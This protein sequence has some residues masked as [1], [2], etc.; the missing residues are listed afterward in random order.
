MAS[1]VA[2]GERGAKDE[3]WGVVTS[4][5]PL[6]GSPA[7]HSPN[8][9][10]L[11]ALFNSADPDNPNEANNRQAQE[12]ELEKWARGLAFAALANLSRSMPCRQLAFKLA[13]EAGVPLPYV[14]PNATTTS[15][16]HPGADSALLKDSVADLRHAPPPPAWAYLG[17]ELVEALNLRNNGSSDGTGGAG[18]AAGGRK[19]LPLRPATTG[20]IARRRRGGNT[21]TSTSQDWGRGT[22]VHA[23]KAHRAAMKQELEGSREGDLGL[24]IG[25]K[26]TTMTGEGIGADEGAGKTAPDSVTTEG[27]HLAAVISWFFGADKGQRPHGAPARVFVP[28]PHAAPGYSNHHQDN[29]LAAAGAAADP[30]SSAFHAEA[31]P[32]S[33]AFHAEAFPAGD[34]AAGDENENRNNTERPL[35]PAEPTHL[36]PSTTELP[37]NS[38]ATAERLA[39]GAMSFKEGS[40]D[41]GGLAAQRRR[42]ATAHDSPMHH[43]DDEEHGF[44]GHESFLHGRAV[45]KAYPAGADAWHPDIA[46]ATLKPNATAVV[47][48]AKAQVHSKTALKVSASARAANAASSATASAAAAFKGSFDHGAPSNASG[49]QGTN[50]S[51]GGGK[52]SANAGNKKTKPRKL[53]LKAPLSTKPTGKAA[54]IDPRI[55][56]GP[57]VA[58]ALAPATYENNKFEWG[59]EHAPLPP[60]KRVLGGEGSGGGK[61]STAGH[62][63]PQSAAPLGTSSTPSTPLVPSSGRIW[64]WPHVAGSRVGVDCGLVPFTATS[65]GSTKNNSNGNNKASNNFQGGDGD[66]GDAFDTEEEPFHGLNGSAN[67]TSGNDPYGPG[68]HFFHRPN[69]SSAPFPAPPI[70]V[71]LPP[72]DLGRLFQTGLPEGAPP[73]VPAPDGSGGGSGDPSAMSVGNWALVLDVGVM[74]QWTTPPPWALPVEE[75][76]ELIP[77]R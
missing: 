37:L 28:R 40:V 26:G 60:L 32:P 6:N 62:Q 22:A 61:K 4:N 29:S 35:N 73:L 75:P 16:S 59:K 33:S 34:V 54:A 18:A 41:D 36:D 14:H 58:V 30:P 39:V 56:R 24:M 63:R 47:A 45:K 42:P 13:L 25:S 65:N 50:S 55:A 48:A 3:D 64:M 21:N 53:K 43:Q 31:F 38:P 19:T 7:P 70:P 2:S 76:S 57:G 69:A 68:F 72:N 49:N 1:M 10:R 77:V 20:N 66:G 8:T 15:A 9:A 67:E 74:Q 44:F 17:N 12:D 51:L 46:N 11:H 5:H 52:S 71:P 23:A 27:G